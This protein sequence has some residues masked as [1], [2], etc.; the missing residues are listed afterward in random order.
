MAKIKKEKT[1]NG[2]TW[3]EARYEG[4]ITSALRAAFRRWQPK[5][6]CLKQAYVETKI[7]P[8]S[9]RLAKHYKCKRCKELFTQTNV[10]VDHK[11]PIGSCSTWDEFVEKLFALN[12]VFQCPRRGE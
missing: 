12:V 10:Q 11:E 1:R 6:E 9:G 3:T 8:K 2:Q 4:F 5:Y 7:N